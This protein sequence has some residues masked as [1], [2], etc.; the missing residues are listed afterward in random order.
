MKIQGCNVAT[1]SPYLGKWY[2]CSKKGEKE[3][4]YGEVT[5][6]GIIV[7]FII[8][9]IERRREKK[10]KDCAVTEEMKKHADEEV[11]KFH[12]W[13]NENMAAK[14]GGYFDEKGDDGKDA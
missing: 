12:K 10:R 13:W 8:V 3:M 11:E 9:I 7:F 5:W 4:Y 2:V 14:Y 6:L 1:F